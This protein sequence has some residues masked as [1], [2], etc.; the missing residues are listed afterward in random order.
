[1]IYVSSG[2]GVNVINTPQPVQ[3][4]PG[5]RDVDVTTRTPSDVGIDGASFAS[6]GQKIE[7]LQKDGSQGKHIL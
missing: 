2:K 3:V 6:N 5:D 1:M 7:I 4:Y